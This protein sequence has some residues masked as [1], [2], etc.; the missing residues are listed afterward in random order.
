VAGVE[1]CT[2]EVCAD[3][4]AR[5]GDS[6]GHGFGGRAP[7]LSTRRAIRRGPSL[8]TPAARSPVSGDRRHG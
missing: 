6:D 1:Q 8:R 3:V 4:S 7:S 2:H 5:T